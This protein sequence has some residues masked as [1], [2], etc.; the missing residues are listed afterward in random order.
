MSSILHP[1]SKPASSISSSQ[2]Q[3]NPHHDFSSDSQSLFTLLPEAE[4]AALTTLLSTIMT[5]MRRTITDTVDPRYA[6]K[7]SDSQFDRFTV[8]NPP[9]NPKPDLSDAKV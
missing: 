2:P 5:S 9:D 1:F 6:G 3:P 8:P 4:R 7:S